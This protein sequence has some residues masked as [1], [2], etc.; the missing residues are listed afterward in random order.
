MSQE[1]TDTAPPDR[2]LEEETGDAAAYAEIARQFGDLDSD[3]AAENTHDTD[4]LTSDLE[5]EYAEFMALL[6]ADPQAP[7][8]AKGD[9][10]WVGL[11]AEWVFDPASQRNRILSIQLY[12]P[13]QEAITTD[14]SR[15][16]QLERLSRLILAHSDA[17][18]DRPKLKANL[19]RLIDEAISWKLIADAPKLIYVVGF[20]LRFDLAALGDFG[21]LK[22]EVDTVAGKVAT[23]SADSNFQFS[24]TLATGDLG[25]T[26]LVGL[27]FIDVAAHVP[28]G[29]SLRGIG[30]QLSLP[31]LDIPAPY[32]IERMD[33]YLEK[34]PEGFRAYAMRDAEIAV[35]YARRL[36][37]FAADTLDIQRLPPTASGLAL[38]WC[39]KTIKE[40]GIDP[41]AAFGLHRA[42][43]EAYH[44]PTRKIRAF[45]EVEPTPM[46]RIQEAF[47]TDCYAGG[48][49]ESFYIGP[50]PYGRWRDY[51]L[52]GAYS[53]GLMD[54]PL[55]DFEH[56]RSTT[57]VRDYLGHVAGYALIDFE[58]HPATRFPVFAVSKAGRGL[59]FPLKGTAYATASEIFAARLLKC[60]IK[61]RWG[62]VFPWKLDDAD[63]DDVPQ[64]RLF[65]PFVVEARR[66]RHQLKQ[67]NN[68]EDTLESLAAKLYA[69]SVYGKIAQS[70]RPKNVFDTRQ[71]RTTRLKPSPITN[72]AIAAHVTGFIRAILA[73][74]L[75]RIPRDRM[76]L[77]VTTDGF[78]SNA[79][80]TEI[81]LSGPLCRRFQALCDDLAQE[82]VDDKGRVPQIP[83]LEVKHAAAQVLCMK[84]RGQ[85][86]SVP[87]KKRKIITA[88]AGV[89]VAI[90]APSNTTGEA[91]RRLQNE[92]M[93]DLYLNRTPATLIKVRQFPS[94]RDQWEKGIDLYKFTR[95][96]RLSLEPDLKR[97]PVEGTLIEQ[98][99]GYSGFT[100]VALDTAPWR[101]EGEF[102]AARAALD[103]WRR[104]NCLCTAEDWRSFKRTMVMSLIRR[105]QRAL[106]EPT[107]NIHADR[108]MSDALRRAFLRAYAHKALGLE[109]THTYREVAAWLS[110]NLYKTTQAEA[111]SAKGQQLVL[112]GV[113][114]LDDVAPLMQLLKN[115]FPE[116]DLD[117]LLAVD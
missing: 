58:H 77:S 117:Q 98:A 66:L 84:I 26:T 36:A 35:F 5:A 74:I 60:K 72:P 71:V 22:T 17:M 4:E 59:I 61:I 21:D 20:G 10:L 73:E 33:E 107:L 103:G 93:L 75:N 94:I 34:D 96:I 116:A 67:A 19:V 104:D 57:R 46:R 29:T 105:R 8:Y 112:R 64:T 89:Q 99:V 52:A 108:P 97:R 95:E 28:P 63:T 50:S 49:N 9:A 15:L 2:I 30:Q 11:D 111:Q 82:L 44:H 41:L 83:M 25:E 56:P 54:I 102:E 106:G 24:R 90:D 6:D 109:R 38:N 88:R 76:V 70:L 43:H 53:T 62:V 7:Q 47:L 13:R 91:Y 85:L 42:R 79:G 40:A 39:M 78:I 48:R 51:D 31:K 92:A 113:P 81:D 80:P 101:D 3:E 68:G 65:R 110:D 37:A 114:L 32:S 55:I 14:D 100:H 1:T 86:T 45:H 23:V 18:E 87:F 115:K 27:R 16:P 69:N 12:V